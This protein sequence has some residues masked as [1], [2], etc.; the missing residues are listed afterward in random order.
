M[1]SYMAGPMSGPEDSTR[2]AGEHD[3]APCWRDLLASHL[4]RMVPYV[5]GRLGGALRL[6]ESASDLVHSVCGDLL[7]EEPDFE[8]R[9]EAQFVRW[10]Q[11][12]VMNKVRARLRSLGA[13]KRGAPAHQ[14]PDAFPLDQVHGNLLS[15]TEQ[16]SLHEDLQRLD[17]AMARLPEHYRE[18]LVRTR[19]LG[20]TREQVALAL[21]RSE[22]S[23]RNLVPRALARLASELDR[24]QQP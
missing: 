5:R 10:L 3:G 18:V 4:P 12:V 14:G 23:L 19:L 11:V 8:Y 9:T 17:Q 24:G 6:H 2:Q 13:K 21:G 22:A 15:P 1:N 16:A 20:Q 7:S